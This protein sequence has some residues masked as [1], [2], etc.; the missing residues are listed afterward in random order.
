MSNTYLNIDYVTVT[1]VSEKS[2]A[3]NLSFYGKPKGLKSLKDQCKSLNLYIDTV[4]E[5]QNDFANLTCLN[6]EP[7][8]LSE[9]QLKWGFVDPKTGE[10]IVDVTKEY[11]R[12]Q[13]YWILRGCVQYLNTRSYLFYDILNNPE[14]LKLKD[15]LGYLDREIAKTGDDLLKVQDKIE[16]ASV[17]A[18]T[19]AWRLVFV[20]NKVNVEV[21][22]E[23]AKNLYRDLL[24]AEDNLNLKMHVKETNQTKYETKLALIV[25]S[26]EIL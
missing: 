18:S 9:D 13:K 20:F 3:K 26:Y 21:V 8:A 4:A 2:F 16:K 10:V 14:T 17:P 1:D 24:R 22:G 7:R 15:I 6:L 5:L 23:A 12:S 11:G 25:D 19:E